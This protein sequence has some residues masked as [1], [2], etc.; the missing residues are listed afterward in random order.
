MRGLRFCCAISSRKVRRTSK[1]PPGKRHLD[2]VLIVELGDAFAEQPDDMR[3]IERRRDRHHGA[4]LG[5]AVRGGEHR[6]A[7]KAVADQD[8]RR[9][10]CRPQMIGGGDQIVDVRRERGVGKLALAG[11]DPGEIE[12]QHRDAVQLQPFGNMA[13]RPIALA[14]GEAMRKQRH[15]ANRAVRPVEQRGELVALG[16]AEIE[17]FGGHGWLLHFAKLMLVYINMHA[18]MR[19]ECSQRFAAPADERARG[20]PFPVSVLKENG[21]PGGARGLRDPLPELAR[22]RD[23]APDERGCDARSRGAAS[24][25][26]GL[27][28]PLNGRCASRR[29]T[30]PANFHRPVAKA[31][32]EMRHHLHKLHLRRVMIAPS[33]KSS[34]RN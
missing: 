23:R 20:R 29:S 3:R 13:R 21:A 19:S 11:A 31:A 32:A 5:D 27:R 15:R 26:T 14:A 9:H 22:L 8:R 16:V 30:R 2:L 12:A 34:T 18:T 1:R 6:G 24:D 17:F 33:T 28:S 7:A 4:R 25:P 10:E